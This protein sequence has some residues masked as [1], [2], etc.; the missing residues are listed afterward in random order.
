MDVILEMIS[1]G[2]LGGVLILALKSGVGCGL[3]N[4]SRKELMMFASMYAVIAL[5]MGAGI[6][7]IP[8]DLTEQVVGLGLLMHTAIG[9]GLVYVGIQTGRRWHCETCDISRRTFLWLSLP[10]PACLAATFFSCMILIETTGY[11][12]LTIGAIV[13]AIFSGG[14]IIGAVA[15]NR[16]TRRYHL[17]KPTVLGSVMLFLGLFYLVTPLIVFAYM[18]MESVPIINNTTDITGTI[19]AMAIMGAIILLGVLIER[20]RQMRKVGGQ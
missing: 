20:T 3:S 7:Y 8:L 2:I 18:K 9:L 11:A 6:E 16:I 12:G 4:L 14:V 19:T 17:D 5:I 1:A 15:M 13:G 10:C